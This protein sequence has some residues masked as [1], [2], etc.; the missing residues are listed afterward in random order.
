MK[1][2][3]SLIFRTI[4]NKLWFLLYF[5]LFKLEFNL[6]PVF[7]GSLLVSGK[8][9]V[10]INLPEAPSFI[11]VYFDGSATT[12]PCNPQHSDTLTYNLDLCCLLLTISWD[13]DSV[14]TVVWEIY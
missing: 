6:K 4:Y 14:R 10:E 2:N 13:V 5:L 9:S 7:S 3:I 1:N 12:I 8:N 11:K